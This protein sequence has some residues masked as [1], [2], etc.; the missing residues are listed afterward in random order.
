MGQADATVRCPA[1]PRPTA[2]LGLGFLLGLTVALLWMH[3][4]LTGRASAQPPA[5]TAEI[6][7][8]SISSWG[9]GNGNSGFKSGASA[10]DVYTGEVF[11]VEEG[12]QPKSLGQPE[13]K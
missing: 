11:I 7:R 9:S 3:V 13:K 12:K 6:P 1:L 2:L 10:I 5:K 8:Y 4:P